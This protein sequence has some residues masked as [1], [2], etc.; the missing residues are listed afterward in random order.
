[1]I[2]FNDLEKEVKGQ[3]ENCN[4]YFKDNKTALYNYLKKEC[5]QLEN[6]K[7]KYS[8]NPINKGDIKISIT[9]DGRSIKKMIITKKKVNTQQCL[10]PFLPSVV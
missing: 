9:F 5:E 6:K 3:L 2:D 7:Y 1:M 8:V 10:T 4:P